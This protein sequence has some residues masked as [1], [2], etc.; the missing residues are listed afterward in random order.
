MT[1]VTE[2]TPVVEIV[3]FTEELPEGI[4]M[5]VGTLATVGILLARL[6]IAPPV[7]A[8][9]VSVT[10]PCAEA[11]PV[12]DVGLTLIAFKA[13]VTVREVVSVPPL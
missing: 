1:F 3:K 4:V 7:L 12:S 8:G 2:V 10:V 11:P 5:E 9:P 6:T 13:G